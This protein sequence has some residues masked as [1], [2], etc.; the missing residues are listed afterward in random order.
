[1]RADVGPV[2]EDVAPSPGVDACNEFHPLLVGRLP[3]LQQLRRVLAAVIELVNLPVAFVADEHQVVGQVEL[4]VGHPLVPARPGRAECVDVGLL[5][6][7]DRLLGHRRPE[8]HLVA[9]GEFAPPGGPAPERRFDGPFDVATR[10]LPDPI[11]QR[12]AFGLGRFSRH[13]STHSLA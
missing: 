1:M 5:P 12:N 9:S 6:R 10:R 11:G 13:S 8:E 7:V 3:S 4:V 2:E